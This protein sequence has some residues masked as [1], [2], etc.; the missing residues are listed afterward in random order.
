VD[1]PR[2]D[3]GAT[4]RAFTLCSEHAYDILQKNVSSFVKCAPQ[5][6][7]VGHVD[8]QTSGNHYVVINIRLLMSAFRQSRFNDCDL[9]S[10]LSQLCRVE[11]DLHAVSM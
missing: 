1:L 9:S 6:M 7:V 8:E 2:V 4:V 3:C 11:N 10:I 5:L